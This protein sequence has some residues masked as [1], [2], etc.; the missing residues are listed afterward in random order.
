MWA[1]YSNQLPDS[2]PPTT[3]ADLTATA[4]SSTQINL[5]WT[6][7]TDNV[8]VSGYHVYCNKK[9]IGITSGASYQST[10]LRPSKTYKFSVAAFDGS[11]NVSH[12]SP[13]VTIKTPPLPS[14]KFTINDPIQTTRQTS[15]YSTPSGDG[16]PVGAQLKKAIGIVIG[17][18]RYENRRWWWLVD[19][20]NNP[21]GWVLQAKLK[22][23]HSGM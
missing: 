18:P 10:G 20:D 17:G 15:V 14:T 5:S 12:E 21:D 11:G 23:N 3:P 19:F 22:K 1:A 16:T 8:A 2:T 4:I 9:Q 6:A 13:V 7:S